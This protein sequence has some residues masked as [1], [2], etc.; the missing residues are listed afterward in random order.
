MVG[1]GRDRAGAGIG[2][3]VELGLEAEEAAVEGDAVAV[4]DRLADAHQRGDELADGQVERE[5]QVVLHGGGEGLGDGDDERA[6]SH[7]QGEDPVPHGQLAR[8]EAAHVGAR[9]REA[10]RRRGGQA[11]ALGDQG[12][13][14]LL[15]EGAELEE[16][17]GE[18]ASVEDLPRDRVLDGAHGGGP[19]LDQDRA[20]GR[21]R[22]KRI[23]GWARGADRA[24]A[25][26]VEMAP[27]SQR[28]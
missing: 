18:I 15:A 20:Q 11:H 6:V 3:A 1:G 10:A 14:H 9:Q 19:S 27:Q 7:R 26:L 4:G 28:A 23:I 25:M 2:A 8:D 12:A 17:G 22:G 24:P 5:A 16:V 21:H 13:E